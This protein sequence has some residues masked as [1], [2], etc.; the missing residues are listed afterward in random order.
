MVTP[1]YKSGDK[2]NPVNYRSVS[3]TSVVCRLLEKITKKQWVEVLEKLEI[4]S[5]K[6]FEHETPCVK[7]Q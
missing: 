3:L 7:T 6:Q 4:I 1:L 5:N 2:Q